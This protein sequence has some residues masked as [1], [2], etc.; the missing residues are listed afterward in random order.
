MTKQ[1]LSVR[2]ALLLGLVAV[3]SPFAAPSAAS[4]ATCADYPDQASG[5]RAADTRD[6]D[7]DGLYC[8]TL[9]CPCLG[10]A[11]GDTPP[12]PSRAS[13]ATPGGV[14]QHPLQPRAVPQYPRPFPCGAAPGLAAHARRQPSRCR[15]APRPL[16][17]RHA[18]PRPPTTATSTRRPSAAGAGRGLVGGARPARLEGR[19]ALRAERREPLPRLVARRQ[20]A[21]VLR[22]HA[23]P[24]RLPLSVSH[25]AS[26]RDQRLELAER[27][28]AR[29]VLHAA[30]GRGHELARR[31]CTA[32]PARIRSATS[33]GV[34]TS[35][36]SSRSSTPRMIVLPGSPS[37]TEQSSSDCAVSI[38]I[39]SQP[40]PASSVRN[41]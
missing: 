7:G 28:L 34:S 12:P 38:E 23:L 31:A 33:S 14:Q 41:E 35:A 24:L 15:R 2:L 17:R 30:V 29:Q 18:D 10:A 22:R 16:T 27:D 20:A 5:Q 11:G 13:C 1:S 21:A 19:R 40:A 32:A 39:W 37:S 8:E 36:P 9:P 3:V 25:D 6:A 4:A 26:A